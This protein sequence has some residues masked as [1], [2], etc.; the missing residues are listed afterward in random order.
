MHQTEFLG[1][2][3]MTCRRVLYVFAEPESIRIHDLILIYI[4]FIYIQKLKRNTYCFYALI[5]SHLRPPHYHFLSNFPIIVFNIYFLFY[6]NIYT[7]SN[8][9]PPLPF[10]SPLPST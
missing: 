2:V 10:I 3:F 7:F 8:L 5:K 9:F 1:F 6:F 4:I